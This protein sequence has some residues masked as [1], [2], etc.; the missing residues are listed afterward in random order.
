MIIGSY[1]PIL[2]A[3]VAVAAAF[4]VRHPAQASFIVD[5]WR[6][7]CV[8]QDTSGSTST[9]I[10][11]DAR[12][13]F[14]DQH[15]A[16]ISGGTASAGYNALFGSQALD[17]HVDASVLG[18]GSVNPPHRFISGCNGNIVLT[19]DATPLSVSVDSSFTWQLPGGARDAYLSYTVHRGG[20][21]D[22]LVGG[23]GA[24]PDAGDPPSGT[25]TP[26]GSVILPANGTYSLNYEMFVDAYS[27]S[28][29]AIGHGDGFVN[30]HATVV[31]ETGTL[32]LIALGAL[33]ARRRLTSTSHPRATHPG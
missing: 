2:F 17:F 6:L 8:V 5:S 1:R 24:S 4:P 26:H 12:S 16:A 22:L 15:Q 28:P 19:N 23:G 33:S 29:S 7:S 21:E 27:G 10:F 32:T 3:L 18:P 14:V 13:P 20:G 31:P 30:L 25:V 11:R 9:A